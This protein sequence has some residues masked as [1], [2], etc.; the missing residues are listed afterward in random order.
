MKNNY[1]VPGCKMTSRFGMSHN[2]ARRAVKAGFIACAAEAG[3]IAC[4]AEAACYG[5]DPSFSRKEW[6]RRQR[7][8]LRRLRTHKKGLPLFDMD[9]SHYHETTLGYFHEVNK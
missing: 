8:G 3:F 9:G 1:K 7:W 5:R 4:A 6:Q 2:E